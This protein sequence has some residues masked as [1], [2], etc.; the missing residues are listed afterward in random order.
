MFYLLFKNLYVSTLL[1]SLLLL[2]RH[3]LFS[4]HFVLFVITDKI[5]VAEKKWV[6]I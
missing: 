2:G 5:A 4:K 6:L 3:L 1:L